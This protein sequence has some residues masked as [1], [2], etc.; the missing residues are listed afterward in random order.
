MTFEQVL[1]KIKEPEK[2]ADPRE[3][4]ALIFEVSGWIGDYEE[5]LATNDQV[6]A[7]LYDN[8]AE[9]HGSDAAGKRK[10]ALTDEYKEHKRVERVI[11][12]LKAFKANL[13][14]RYEILTG[15]FR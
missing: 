4:D 5:T 11:K 9:K 13:K 1:E 12:R 6:I 10:L 15:S 8:L 14:R 2:L 7:V 3:V